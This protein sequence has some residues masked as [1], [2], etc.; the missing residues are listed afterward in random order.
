[1][2]QTSS[3]LPHMSKSGPSGVW[4][5][6]WTE[7]ALDRIHDYVLFFFFKV[8]VVKFVVYFGD[9]QYSLASFLFTALLL[10]VPPVGD[11]SYKRLKLRLSLHLRICA[12]LIHTGWPKK[13]KPLSLIIIESY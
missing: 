9:G 11:N 3:A 1:M 7:A 13:N 2:P 4:T 8:S 12:V 6:V 5:S 10:T